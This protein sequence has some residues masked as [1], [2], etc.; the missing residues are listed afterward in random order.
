MFLP[1]ADCMIA[2]FIIH[3]VE[4]GLFPILKHVTMSDMLTGF[5]RV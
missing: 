5:G 2:G 3:S 4:K 1:V